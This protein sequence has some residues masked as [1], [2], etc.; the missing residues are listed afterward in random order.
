ME[1]GISEDDRRCLTWAAIYLIQKVLDKVMP[2]DFEATVM[3]ART[4][5]GVDLDPREA[6]KVLMAEFLKHLPPLGG[7]H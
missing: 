1:P 6:M 2:E 7:K 4:I 5:D 3:E